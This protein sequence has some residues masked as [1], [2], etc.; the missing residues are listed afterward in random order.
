MFQKKHHSQK[1]YTIFFLTF[2][3]DKIPVTVFINCINAGRQSSPEIGNLH[4]VSIHHP[5]VSDSPKPLILETKYTPLT[6][7]S[8]ICIYSVVV[9]EILNSLS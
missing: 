9:L 6:V 2:K 1:Y 4:G 5:V 7:L 3:E 8:G